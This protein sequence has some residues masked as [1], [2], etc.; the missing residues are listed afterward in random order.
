IGG[1]LEVE[2]DPALIEA[3][4]QRR[5]ELDAEAE[6][7][8]SARRADAVAITSGAVHISGTLGEL[9]ARARCI[10]LPLG[11]TELRFH[12]RAPLSPY[13]P[14]KAGRCPAVVAPI[15][16]ASGAQ[17]GTHVTFLQADGSAKRCFEH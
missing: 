16:N 12:S 9:Y 2:P 3:R 14:A 6:R 4:E 11:Q 10:R 15:R 1:G 13:E 8:R 5:R 7:L 17:L